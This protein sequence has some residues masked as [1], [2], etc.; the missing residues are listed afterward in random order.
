MWCPWG[1]SI[2]YKVLGENDPTKREKCW[3]AG[4]GFLQVVPGNPL[5]AWKCCD[6]RG[7][8]SMG[9]EWH[10][11]LF[12]T[13]S[14]VTEDGP[15]YGNSAILWLPAM[16]ITTN[17]HFLSTCSV[18]STVL[19][20]EGGFKRDRRHSPVPQAACNLIWELKPTQM[21]RRKNGNKHYFSKCT[22]AW[23]PQMSGC[24]EA[25]R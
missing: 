12:G 25:A 14:V 2:S 20:F 11:L 5:S 23:G 17:H 1:R 22:M 21:M 4:V 19:N 15:T 10:Y 16:T 24:W 3:G 13:L 6:V 8:G 7:G 9:K 18:L